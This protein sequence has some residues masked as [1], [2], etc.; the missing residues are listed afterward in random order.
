M[1]KI[2]NFNNYYKYIQLFVKS[3]IAMTNYTILF[4][5]IYNFLNRIIEI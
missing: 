1:K 2:Y 4:Q 5:N 3:M